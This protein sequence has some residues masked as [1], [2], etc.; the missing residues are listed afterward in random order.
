MSGKNID[1]EIEWWRKASID[2][3][4]PEVQMACWGVATGLKMAKEDFNAGLP[5]P[6]FRDIREKE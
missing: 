4:H 3:K 6:K 5:Q 2:Q 1:T